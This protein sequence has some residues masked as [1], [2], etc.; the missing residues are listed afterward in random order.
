MIK[1]DCY[2]NIGKIISAIE[3]SGF[4]I[5]NIKMTKME[6]QDSQQ[7]YAEH[8]V[9]RFKLSN[10]Q[11]K[12]FFEELTKFIASD[13]IVGMELVSEDCI[14]RW[15]QLIGPTNC[16][17]ARVE[18]PNSL[19]ALYGTEGVRNACH[20]SDSGNIHLE[21]LIAKLRVLPG[22]LI[23]SLARKLT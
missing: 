6:L 17:I 7:F 3:Q 4:V 15:R 19:R 13:Y 20:G 23:F 16:Q 8:R 11:G 5:S 9:G 14:R 22:S 2:K 12:P 1:P 18:A 10:I 21:L